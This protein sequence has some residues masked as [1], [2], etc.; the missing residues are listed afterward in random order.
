MITPLLLG[1]RELR[2]VQFSGVQAMKQSLKA[3]TPPLGMWLDRLVSP[4][5]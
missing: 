5:C 4:K 1:G 3:Q 2:T